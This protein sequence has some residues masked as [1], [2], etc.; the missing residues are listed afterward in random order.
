MMD[1]YGLNILESK[2]PFGSPGEHRSCGFII[3]KIKIRVG[4]LNAPSLTAR[5]IELVDLMKG[6]SSLRVQESR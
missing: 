5:G 1:I 6:R 3:N 4:T 2:R